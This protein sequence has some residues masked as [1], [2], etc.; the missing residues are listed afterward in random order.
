MKPRKQDAE[1]EAVDYEQFLRDL[2]ADED[3]R[4]GLKL[5]RDGD[6]APKRGM[7]V[8]GEEDDDEEDEGLEI[9]MEQLID[10]MEDV[11]L[12]DEDVEG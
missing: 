3:L 1:R 10:E 4:E 5:Y 6:A 12:E 7:E 11:G 8:D 2:E 9:P